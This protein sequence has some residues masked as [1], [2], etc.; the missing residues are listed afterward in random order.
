MKIMDLVTGLIHQLSSVL[1][2]TDYSGAISSR[3]CGLRGVLTALLR[4]F[5][6]VFGKLSFIKNPNNQVLIKQTTR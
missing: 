2:R 1:M 4:S 5:T 3:G 6:T